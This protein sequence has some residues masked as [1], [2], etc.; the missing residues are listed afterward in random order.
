MS[1]RIKLYDGPPANPERQCWLDVLLPTIKRNKVT[2]GFE[3]P[4]LVLTRPKLLWIEVE[5]TDSYE[6]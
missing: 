5:E 4:A 3:I 1:V 6:G 2:H